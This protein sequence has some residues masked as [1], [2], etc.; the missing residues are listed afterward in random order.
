VFELLASADLFVRSAQEAFDRLAG[1]LGLFAPRG[2]WHQDWPE[3]G[4]D[5]RWCRVDLDL[6]VAP[7][8]LEII[9]PY[10]SA[11]PALGHP[12]MAEMFAG[13]GARPYKTHS[14]PVSTGDIE[15][16]VSRLSKARVPFRL[17]EPEGALPFPRLWLGRCAGRPG[18][19]DPAADGGLYLE[20]IPALHFPRPDG[21]RPA[22]PPREGR[23][24]RRIAARRMLVPDVEAT[25]RTLARTTGWTPAT[26]IHL[27]GGCKTA[28]YTFGHPSSATLD[29]VEP[30][31]G[32]R[33]AGYYERWGAGPYGITLETAD[34]D[35]AAGLWRSSGIGVEWDETGD[36][37]RI[38]PDHRQ[39]YGVQ[40]EITGTG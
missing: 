20:F 30:G 13:Q 40:F 15:G 32:T 31:A 23:P 5:A 33:E 17:D 25:V 22:K 10:P 3:W 7:T 18:A 2:I 35:L 14:T 26:A 1:P 29:V 9:A 4:F 36:A 34:L 39:T 11:D 24:V 27:R 16:L 12:Q 21:A 37:P 38:L 28:V 6:A 8:H 19:Y